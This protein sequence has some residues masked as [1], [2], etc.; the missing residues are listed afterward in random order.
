DGAVVYLNGTE[1]YR[2]NMPTGAIAYNT[3]ASATVGGTDESFWYITPAAMP[4]LRTGNNVIA[5]EIHQSDVTSSDIS[6]DLQLLATPMPPPPPLS[7]P[8]GLQAA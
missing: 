2:N 7:A 1:V 5:V 6:F 3:L 8:S 4:L